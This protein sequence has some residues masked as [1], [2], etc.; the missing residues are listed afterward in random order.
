MIIH[1]HG[2]DIMRSLQ[3]F[4]NL[5]GSLYVLAGHSHPDVLNLLRLSFGN[6]ALT[7]LHRLFE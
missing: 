6:S 3:L 5:N 7:M 4:G 2:L 1:V